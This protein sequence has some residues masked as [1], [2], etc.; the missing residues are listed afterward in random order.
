MT[1]SKAPALLTR[2]QI[3]AT[4]LPHVDIDVPALGGTVRLQ[5]FSATTGVEVVKTYTDNLSAVNAHEVDQA[6]PEADRE[7][8][9]PVKPFDHILVQLL[10]AIVD[11]DGHPIFTIDDYEWFA[12]QFSY[13][14][15]RQLWTAFIGLTRSE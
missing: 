3:L 10:Y 5:A 12:D 2:D 1:K 8:L 4:K 6:K 14:V 9:P 13:E 15:L 11:Q 7:G